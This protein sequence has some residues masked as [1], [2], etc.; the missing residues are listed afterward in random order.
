[1]VMGIAKDGHKIMG[2]YK[3]DKTLWQPC[4]VDFCN[5]VTQNGE[6]FYVMTLFH[7]YTLNC[8]GPSTTDNIYRA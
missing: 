3:Q 8:W 7:P 4:D 2:P 6:Y 5:G 1:M